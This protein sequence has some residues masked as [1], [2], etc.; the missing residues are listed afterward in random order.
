MDLAQRIRPASVIRYG[1]DEFE[2]AAGKSL[3]IET[4]PGGMEILNQECPAGKKYTVRV[5]VQITETDV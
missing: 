3:K 1:S 4:G 2:C 5:S